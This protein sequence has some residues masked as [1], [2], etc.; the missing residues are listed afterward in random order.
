M[1]PVVTVHRSSLG[2]AVWKT[3]DGVSANT[4]SS[5]G[6]NRTTWGRGT[7]GAFAYDVPMGRREVGR[8]QSRTS[9]SRTITLSNCVNAKAPSLLKDCDAG[10]HEWSR[11]QTGETSHLE[12][13]RAHTCLLMPLARP[14]WRL[15]ERAA[16]NANAVLLQMV[17][18]R[19]IAIASNHAM[20]R[21]A[22]AHAPHRRGQVCDAVH[23]TPIG[24][25]RPLQED[26]PH[27]RRT[28]RQECE[29]RYT[30]SCASPGVSEL[31]VGE[32]AA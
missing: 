24:S 29:H 14:A 19:C 15:E 30:W 11:C 12:R 32:R 2:M 7:E 21:Q 26:V 8:I 3:A 6:F 18:G 25:L 9:L 17:L 20:Q 23:L 22:R 10:D 27:V 16:Q 4:N 13:G 28:K 5:R 31:A 1:R